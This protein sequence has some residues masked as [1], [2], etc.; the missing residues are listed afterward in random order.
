[1]TM[2]NQDVALEGVHSAEETGGNDLSKLAWSIGLIH[3]L[4][5]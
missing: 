3:S 4:I 5:V 1:M 2:L